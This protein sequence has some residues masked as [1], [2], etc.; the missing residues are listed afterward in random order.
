MCI[1]IYNQATGIHNQVLVN[2]DDCIKKGTKHKILGF[3]VYLLIFNALF[4]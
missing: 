1:I 2:L 3:T 4:L